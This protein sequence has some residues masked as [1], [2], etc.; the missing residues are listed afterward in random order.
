MKLLLPAI[1][2]LLFFS[3]QL[4]ANTSPMPSH[5]VVLLYHHVAEDTPAITSIKP[6][7]FKQ[8]LA[9][10]NDDNFKVWPLLKIVTAIQNKQTIPDKVVAITFDDSYQSVYDQAYPLLKSYDW[11]FTIFVATDAIDGGY[12]HQ[13]SWEQLRTMAANGATISNHSA[14]HAHLL[15]RLD[16]ENKTQWL[17]RVTTDINKAQRRIKEEIKTE[18]TLFAYPYGENNQALRDLVNNLGYVGF[19]QQSGA[20]GEFS[21]QL[22]LPRFPLAGNYSDINDFALKVHTVDLPVVSLQHPDSPLP[23]TQTK[24]TMMMVLA[25]SFINKN[26]LQCFAS[27]QGTVTLQWGEANTVTATPDQNIPQGRSRYNCTAV[28]DAKTQPIRYYWFSMPWL[29]LGEQGEW[30]PE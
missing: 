8:Q 23:H 28:F 24:P 7:L 30:P 9:Y 18:N 20:M 15:K 22:N 11:P 10:L 3:A 6:K 27:N 29:R 21:D 4:P 1:L 2:C 12:N 5:A 19:G 14:S 13:T 25:D 16:N 26:S 17:E